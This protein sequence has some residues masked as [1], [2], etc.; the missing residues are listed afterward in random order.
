MQVLTMDS[1]SV[2]DAS[3][4]AQFPNY[5]Q[6][7]L[8]YMR[9]LSNEKGGQSGNAFVVKEIQKIVADIDKS[10][11]RG[12]HWNSR[13]ESLEALMKQMFLRIDELEGQIKRL[14]RVFSS[15]LPKDAK[16][17]HKPPVPA[18]NKQEP[19]PKKE[20]EGVDDDFDLFGDDEVDE[21]KP[22]YVPVVAKP[23]K[24]EAPVAKSMIVLDVKPWDD[25]TNMEELE[26]KVREIS[27]DGLVWGTGKLVPLAY[28][29]KKLQIACVV[30]DDKVG[31]DFLEESITAIEDYVQSVDIASF[32]KL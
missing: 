5:P 25:T 16:P 19:A 17:V 13:V 31:S 3:H 20:E 32:N 14:G 23:K 8:D 12:D 7:E 22:K 11:D 18:A 1:A 15:E 6:I 26:A 24:K 21:S 29:I 27:T 9:F 30:E 10:L 4:Y 2:F 28:G